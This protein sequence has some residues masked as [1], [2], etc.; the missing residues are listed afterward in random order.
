[1]AADATSEMTYI[2]DLDSLINQVL[3]ITE[4]DD[5]GRLSETLTNNVEGYQVN[6]DEGTVT[7]SL[8]G[9][10]KKTLPYDKDTGLIQGLDYHADR[11]SE[12][13]LFRAYM[14]RV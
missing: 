2:K 3:Y 14:K 6:E 4:Y 1:M 8:K 10:Y 12:L 13:W 7:F 11:L 9:D 5:D